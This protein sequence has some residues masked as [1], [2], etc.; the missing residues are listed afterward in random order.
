MPPAPTAPILLAALLLAACAA[1]PD[2]PQTAGAAE[3]TEW[4]R[5]VPL[6]PLL[7]AVPPGGTAA[8]AQTA[9]VEGRLDSLR[10]RADALRGP[11]VDP[12]TRARMGA[13]VEVPPAL[14]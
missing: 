10:T 11:V 6:Q 5:L 3:G 9:V 7:A 4:P 12:G 14:R 1:P 13:G 2:L 8:P